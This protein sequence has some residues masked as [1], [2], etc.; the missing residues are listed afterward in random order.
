MD[1]VPLVSAPEEHYRHL[2]T[3]LVIGTV[4]V[5]HGLAGIADLAVAYLYKDEFLVSPST[6]SFLMTATNVAWILKPLWGFTS[7]SVPI[8]SKRRMPYLMGFALLSAVLWIAL[9]SSHYISLAVLILSLNSVCTAFCNVIAEALV[10]EESQRQGATQSQATK[11]VTFFF[12]LRA[13]GYMLTAYLSGFLIEAL[14][15]RAVIAL[16]AVFPAILFTVA[17]VLPEDPISY[18]NS[19]SMSTQLSLFKSFVCRRGIAVPTLF[20]FIFVSTPGTSDAMFFFYTNELG[21]SPEFMGRLRLAQ[22]IAMILSM[23]AYQKWL[24]NINFK[25]ILSCSAVFYAL[26]NL[27]QVL[28]VTRTNSAIGIPDNVFCYCS[29]F[30]SVV[31]GELNIMPIL[32]LCARICPKNIEGT[33]YAFFMSILNLGY[34]TSATTSSVIMTLLQITQTDFDMLWLMIVLCSIMLVLPLPLLLCL[35]VPEVTEADVQSQPKDDA[36][37]GSQQSQLE[38]LAS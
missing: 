15:V 6:Y 24:K 33:M 4:A 16:T 38:V 23:F 25:W 19:I 3:R 5:T 32:V 11:N 10:V 31:L 28:L 34:F 27:A 13:I 30:I 26:V 12:A 36:S 20:I 17:W 18:K 21:F 22:G 14:S 35:E 2:L 7:D 8:C 9:A 29:S 1:S 37:S